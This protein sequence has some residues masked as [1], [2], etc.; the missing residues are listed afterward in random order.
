[1]SSVSEHLDPKQNSL[2]WLRNA[3]KTASLKQKDNGEPEIT[4]PNNLELN[5]SSSV[6]DLFDND[7]DYSP[8]FEDASETD[9]GSI[10]DE[11]NKIASQSPIG[12]YDNTNSEKSVEEILKEA[13]KLYMESSKSFEQLSLKSKTPDFSI[14]KSKSSVSFKS[15][16]RSAPSPIVVPVLDKLTLPSDRTDKTMDSDKTEIPSPEDEEVNLLWEKE[17]DEVLNLEKP[18][19]E[20]SIDLKSLRDFEEKLYEAEKMKENIDDLFEENMNE[21]KVNLE[22]FTRTEREKLDNNI[23]NLLCNKNNNNNNKEVNEEQEDAQDEAIN[24]LHEEIDN[25][26]VRKLYLICSI[27]IYFV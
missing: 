14:P 27:Y 23:D 17:N 21:L 5:I 10:I 4:S 18:P 9:I 22:E 8:S 3:V 1:M 7:D 2:W 19:S 12:N 15:Y 13:E 25:L 11:I 24:K 26:K 6:E 20:L 16:K